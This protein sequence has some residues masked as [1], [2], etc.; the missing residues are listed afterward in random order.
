MDILSDGEHTTIAMLADPTSHQR[1]A[2]QLIGAA[3]PLTLK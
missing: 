2:F 3:I 1:E